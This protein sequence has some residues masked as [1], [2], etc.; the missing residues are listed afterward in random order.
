MTHKFGNLFNL[1]VF[2][3]CFF[4]VFFLWIK[5]KKNYLALSADA[6]LEA[7][8]RGWCKERMP[9]YAAPTR[10]LIVGRLPRNVMGKVNKKEL[11][12]Q[13][14]PPPSPAAESRIEL[15]KWEQKRRR[16]EGKKEKKTEKF[17]RIKKKETFFYCKNVTRLSV[18]PHTFLV[19]FSFTLPANLLTWLITKGKNG[20][21]MEEKR[22]SLPDTRL[23]N[24]GPFSRD[25]VLYFSFSN[26]LARKKN[27]KMLLSFEPRLTTPRHGPGWNLKKKH[28]KY[29]KKR[30]K[31]SRVIPV[32]IRKKNLKRNQCLHGTG[33]YS[34]IGWEGKK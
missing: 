32:K 1:M 2:H 14:F 11:I 19:F 18:P 28:E 15:G 29:Q 12:R 17:Q 10:W 16:N 34:V 27:K 24:G 22:V 8:L 26:G 23:H 31:A 7:E 5:T 9:P 20:N 21:K 13:L 3:R 6:V 4:F 25:V 30:K 33:I